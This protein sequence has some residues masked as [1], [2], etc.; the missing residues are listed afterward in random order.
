[1]Y[2]PIHQQPP[3]LDESASFSL[4]TGVLGPAM[5]AAGKAEKHGDVGGVACPLETK[6]LYLSTPFFIREQQSR[7]A[8]ASG[9]AIQ[10]EVPTLFIVERAA[11][12]VDPPP[13]AVDSTTARESP[14]D[15]DDT[16]Q[17]SAHVPVT[18]IAFGGLRSRPAVKST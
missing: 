14:A 11:F 7:D 16:A 9:S 3:T 2:P 5:L 18:N 10:D 4:A 8:S 12:E 17:D 15:E 6:D 13:I 1:M